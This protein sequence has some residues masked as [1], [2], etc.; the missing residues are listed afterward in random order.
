MW[1]NGL[2]AVAA[3]AAARRARTAGATELSAAKVI[4][5]GRDRRRG[6]NGGISSYVDG[7]AGVP[8]RVQPP[9]APQVL[10][11]RHLHAYRV[12]FAPGSI[13]A[14]GIG[15]LT[16]SLIDACRRHPHVFLSHTFHLDPAANAYGNDRWPRV[17]RRTFA[18][19]PSMEVHRRC[20]LQARHAGDA[21][22][23]HCTIQQG[24]VR[25]VHR[26]KST[27]VP[28]KMD[29]SRGGAPLVSLA[30]APAFLSAQEDDHGRQARVAREKI[31]W[32]NRH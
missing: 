15:R 32:G 30:S 12:N 10:S 4:A 19:C 9:L 25:T 2:S 31:R 28:V 21:V 7:A 18:H 8:H 20:S 3:C 26:R 22:F 17:G 5:C 23:D 13:A 6:P 11:F 29:S 14:R 16:R 24:A 1:T 27:L